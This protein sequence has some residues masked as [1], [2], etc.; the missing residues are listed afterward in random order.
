MI[1]FLP[2]K[3]HKY[4]VVVIC[5]LTDPNFCSI[6]LCGYIGEVIKFRCS[7]KGDDKMF[8]WTKMGIDRSCP[9]KI[10]DEEKD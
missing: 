4:K 8:H 7:K 9:N 1:L 5:K 10:V 3:T 2:W 6:T